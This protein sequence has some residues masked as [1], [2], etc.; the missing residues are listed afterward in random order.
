[1]TLAKAS[2]RSLLAAVS[3]GVACLSAGPIHAVPI[4]YIDSGTGSGSIGDQSFTGSL[5]TVT[6]V[7]DTA[8]VTGGPTFFSNAIG[9]ATVDIAGIGTATFTAPTIQAFVNQT[10][11]PAFAGIGDSAQGSILDTGNE[12]AFS[13]YDLT[14]AIGPILGVPFIRPDLSFATNLGLFNLQTMGDTTFTAITGAAPAPEPNSVLLLGIIAL[15]TLLI[16]ARL[17]KGH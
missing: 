1:M 3:F 16:R 7:G 4:T 10:F 6:F 9:T 2:I 8:N 13:T 5:V 17:R 12:A 14:T 11:G 15:G